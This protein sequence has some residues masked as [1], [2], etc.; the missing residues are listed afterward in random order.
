VVQEFLS[1]GSHSRVLYSW[2]TSFL[3]KGESK[4]FSGKGKLKE[5]VVSKTTSKEG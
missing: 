3:N 4:V 2:K 5:C 1:S